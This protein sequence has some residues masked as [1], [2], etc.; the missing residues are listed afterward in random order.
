MNFLKPVSLSISVKYYHMINYV[1]SYIHSYVNEGVFLLHTILLFTV[2]IQLAGSIKEIVYHTRFSLLTIT[3]CTTYI[4][5]N[6]RYE[7]KK[8]I[9]CCLIILFDFS[10]VEYITCSGNFRELI[11]PLKAHGTIK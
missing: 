9:T 3:V 1:C 2:N 7:F 6:G 4:R 5:R 10:F 11:W 8:N